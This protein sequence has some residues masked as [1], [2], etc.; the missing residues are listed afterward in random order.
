MAE[1]NTHLHRQKLALQSDAKTKFER[2]AI[3]LYNKLW[4]RNMSTVLEVVI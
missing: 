2:K 3:S 1:P 4:Q